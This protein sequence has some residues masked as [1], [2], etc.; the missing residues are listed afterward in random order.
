MDEVKCFLWSIQS[1]RLHKVFDYVNSIDELCSV[2]GMDFMKTITEV[3]PSLDEHSSD[4]SKSISNSTLNRL[5]ESVRSLREE[6]KGRITKVWQL[7]WIRKINGLIF[8][9]LCIKVLIIIWKCTITAPWGQLFTK[10]PLK[11]SKLWVLKCLLENIPKSFNMI[12]MLVWWETYPGE[13]IY[14]P[15]YP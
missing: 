12:R 6:K 7:V 15:K 10:I 8:H 9:L 13:L 2:L 14:L 11:I 5:D 4:Q 3:H 1:E